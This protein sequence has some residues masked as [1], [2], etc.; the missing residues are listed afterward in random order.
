MG[1]R[2]AQAVT[3]PLLLLLCVSALAARP[4][5]AA[6]ELGGVPADEWRGRTI[7]QVV[8]DRFAT[9]LCE[10]RAWWWLLAMGCGWRPGGMMLRARGWLP[11]GC[12]FT[13]GGW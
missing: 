9:S 5:H 8:T 7:Y 1:A 6:G 3:P 4:A 13:G 11:G 10:T 2:S 12:L